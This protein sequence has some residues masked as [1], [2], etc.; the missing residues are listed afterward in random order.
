[1]LNSS[2]RALSNVEASNESSTAPTVVTVTGSDSSTALAVTTVTGSESSTAPA[3]VT[4]T[5]S[6]SSTMP[7]ITAVTGSDPST[8]LAV[9]V[10]ASVAGPSTA[11]AVAAVTGPSPSTPLTV[12]AIEGMSPTQSEI[13]VGIHEVTEK[14]RFNQAEEDA[15]IVEPLTWDKFSKI[16]RKDRKKKGKGEGKETAPPR[17]L[18]TQRSKENNDE[19]DDASQPPRATRS[20][21]NQG[22]GYSKSDAFTIQD[23][24]DVDKNDDVD[25]NNEENKH[26]SKLWDTAS[27]TLTLEF[28]LNS[29]PRFD[30][31]GSSY[32]PQ[33][34]T[35]LRRH[36]EARGHVRTIKQLQNKVTHMRTLWHQREWLKKQSGFGIDPTT[37]RITAAENC[38]E[39]LKRVSIFISHL[40]KGLLLRVN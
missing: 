6:E 14:I 11:S 26:G 24:D 27:I 40:L 20:G 3:V 9:A 34:W 23:D 38:W 30:K 31:T 35:E 8:M 32:K 17:R 29:L 36:M 33:L 4:V 10:S 28:I 13:I 18:A 12:P 21:K 1:M 25:E 37:M 7:A 22:R 16:R 15:I 2:P 19:N 39:D 5:G